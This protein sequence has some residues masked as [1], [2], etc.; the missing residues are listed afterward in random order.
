MRLAMLPAAAM[1]V[2]TATGAAAPARQAGI[3]AG[4]NT[5]TYGKKIGLHGT[6]PGAEHAKVAILYR[7]AASRS[8]R[9]VQHTKTGPH[10]FYSTHVKPLKSGAYSARLAGKKP[11][12]TSA[13]AQPIDGYTGKERVQVRSRTVSRVANSATY[14]DTVRVKGKVR[15]TDAGRRVVVRM[16]GAKERT[17]T[18]G[19]GRFTVRLP[20]NKLGT[21][22]VT[23]KSGGSKLASASRDKAGKVTVYRNALASWYGP[24]L[25]GNGVACGGTLTPS[26]I[27]VANK[28]L[29]C[30]TKVK[31]RYHGHSVTAPVIDRGPYS[32]NREFDLTEATKNKLHFPGVATLQASK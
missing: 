22:R 13:A 4:K 27:G 26:T 16:A 2:I 19:H 23:V 30:G 31:F 21:H 28:T 24:G 10:G 7:S 11:V 20:A 12:S 25:Y 1:I 14:G 32:G 5:V 15:P 18:N 3:A 29:P 6:F 8:S 9:V 17:H